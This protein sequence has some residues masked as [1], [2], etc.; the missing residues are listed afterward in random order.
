MKVGAGGG[1]RAIA[2]RTV[3]RI[4]FIGQGRPV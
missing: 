4:F 2:D 3:K 1:S